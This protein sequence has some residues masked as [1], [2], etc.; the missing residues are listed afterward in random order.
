[1]QFNDL[2]LQELV[3]ANLSDFRPH[4]GI[5][6]VSANVFVPDRFNMTG[7]RMAISQ[8]HAV[9]EPASFAL[10]L[11]GILAIVLIPWRAKQT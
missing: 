7:A 9:N 1:M 10:L 6:G 5:S 2:T 8:V 3:D 11:G 4:A